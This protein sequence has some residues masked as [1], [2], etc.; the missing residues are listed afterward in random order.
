MSITARLEE[1]G[2]ST[3]GSCF[4]SSI[5]QQSNSV[6]WTRRYERRSGDADK[7]FNQLYE[8]ISID[9]KRINLSKAAAE[10]RSEHAGIICSSLKLM[11]TIKATFRRW[12]SN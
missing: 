6:L 1:R 9:E 7:C 12:R 8:K 3:T 11:K 2:I 4:L 10:G 5:Y